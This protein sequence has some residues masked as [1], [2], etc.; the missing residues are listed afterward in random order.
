GVGAGYMHTRYK[1]YRSV[2][3]HKLYMST[4]SLNYFGPLKLKFSIAWRFDIMTKT[5]KVNSTL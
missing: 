5:I 4:K 2:D 1:V 3:D